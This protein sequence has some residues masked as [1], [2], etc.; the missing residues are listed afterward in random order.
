MNLLIH[1]ASA[2]LDLVVEIKLVWLGN[3]SS[4]EIAV[5]VDIK[6]DVAPWRPTSGA[7]INVPSGERLLGA[8]GLEFLF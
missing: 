2:G 1:Q 8:E 3:L 4:Q 5:P 7:S 6:W